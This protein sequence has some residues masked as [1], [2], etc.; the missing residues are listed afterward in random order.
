[1]WCRCSFWWHQASLARWDFWWQLLGKGGSGKIWIFRIWSA[2]SC[3]NIFVIIWNIRKIIKIYFRCTT[4]LSSMLK[5]RVWEVC[6]H[7]CAWTNTSQLRNIV[8]WNELKNL[9]KINY[10]SIGRN[11]LTVATIIICPKKRMHF[12]SLLHKIIEIIL[13]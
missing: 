6:A 10:I 3:V 8:L 7:W 2:G 5:R 13:K 11:K 1:M 9:K 12:C 4:L